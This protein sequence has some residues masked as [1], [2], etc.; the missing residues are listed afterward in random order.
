MS[1]KLRLSIIIPTK[2][3]TEVLEKALQRLELKKYL[4]Q[5]EVIVVDNN[6]DSNEKRSLSKL[7][8]KYS[9]VMRLIE[10]QDVSVAGARNR[11]MDKA[12]GEV[13]L[14][15][16][17]DTWVEKDF[18]KIHL[19][20]HRQHKDEE[21]LIGPMKSE[22]VPETDFVNRWL[23]ENG[24]VNFNYLGFDKRYGRVD[25]FFWWTCNL[26]IKS[27]FM[28][29]NKLR[30]DETF[31]TA[32][33][34]DIELG[35]RCKKAGLKLY[36]DPKLAAW[37]HHWFD[38]ASLRGRFYSHGRGMYYLQGK[39]PRNMQP[40]LLKTGLVVVLGGLGNKVIIDGL[41]RVVE[42]VGVDTIKSWLM[43][44]VIVLEKVAGYTYEKKRMSSV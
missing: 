26:S 28:K 31:P 21:A 25:W 44:V 37:H 35:W 23:N 43:E 9:G 39:L 7:A 5:V 30:F 16:N 18:V 41:V 17:D 3:R 12:R 2:D 36:L 40:L 1:K 13:W 27:D 42:W 34:E 22:S 14:F 6:S 33:W 8:K 24:K 32:A 19:D 20:F 29:K 11:A 38:M 10:G 4:D 15:M